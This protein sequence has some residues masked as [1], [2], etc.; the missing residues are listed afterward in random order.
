MKAPLVHIR[1]PDISPM[2][3]FH[4][5]LPLLLQLLI[6]LLPLAMAA[7]EQGRFL[8]PWQES[9]LTH[10]AAPRWDKAAHK[11]LAYHAP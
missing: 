8:A 7:E 9:S 3:Q 1:K 11:R 5:R 2:R 6:L 10:R 4:L